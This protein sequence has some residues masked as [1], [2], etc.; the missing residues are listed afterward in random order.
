MEFHF[1]RRQLRIVFVNG[2]FARLLDGNVKT[3]RL[4]KVRNSKGCTLLAAAK[5]PLIGACRAIR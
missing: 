2:F 3:L 1:W 4:R 5:L